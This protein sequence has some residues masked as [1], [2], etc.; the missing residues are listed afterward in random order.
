MAPTSEHRGHAPVISILLL[1]ALVLAAALSL[2]DS[3]PPAPLPHDVPATVFSAS[4]AMD[5]L[6]RVLGDERPHPTGSAANAAVRDRIVN[7]L[8]ALGLQPEVRARFSCNWRHC[9]TVEN[10]LAR[11]PG[12][13]PGQAVLLSAHYD[14]VAA[15][16]GASDDG[17]GVAAL[18]EVVRALQAG[19][20]LPRD[21]WVL[22]N[23][24]EELGLL[25]AEAFAR[26][27]EFQRIATVVNLEAR[28]TSGASLLIE[29]Q[30]GNAGVIDAVR[31]S[32]ARPAGSSLDYEI[33]KTLPND[34]DFTV[35]R[36]AGLAGTNFAWA[37]DPARYHTPLD[38]L[39]HLDAG[40]LQHHGDN[41]LGMV[42]ALAAGG[43]ALHAAQDAQFFDVLGVAMVTWP[44]SWNLALL[45]VALLAWGGWMLR[46]VRAGQV[47][48]ASLL[49]AGSGS[50]LA[51]L[52]LALV[53]WAWYALLGAAGAMPATWTAQAASL[54]AGF[55]LLALLV[56]CVLA[57]PAVRRLGAPAVVSGSLVPFALVAIFTTLAM[58][59][60]TYMGLV[61]LLAGAFAGHAWLRRP[62]LAG[63]FAAVVAAALWST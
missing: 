5:V 10:I 36:K 60:A 30:Q 63:G 12:E 28:G 58:P 62:I 14:S 53:A 44:V 19:P 8:A 50:L 56:A 38:D 25:G 21:V 43:D 3:H 45:V 49:L 31:E 9:A 23:D 47:R 40:S 20:P 54:V 24:G 46:Q 6:Q 35:Y 29:T 4:R 11:L 37:R 57:R 33:Y 18:I 48:M 13:S 34:T 42:R 7:E 16:P 2:R 39:A 17:A 26:S 61:P 55:L 51:L 32:L 41:T 22:L 1:A 52:L 27:P 15:G 59:G